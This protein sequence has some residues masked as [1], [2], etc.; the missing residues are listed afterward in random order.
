MIAAADRTSASA[1]ATRAASVTPVSLPPR[2]LTLLAAVF[3][4]LLGLSYHVKGHYLLVYGEH[5]SDAIDLRQKWT[6]QQY[7]L[8]RQNPFDVWIRYGPLT[9]TR[10]EPFHHPTRND[11]IDPRLGLRDPAHPPFGFVSALPFFWPD[12]PAVRLW[13]SAL[14]LVATLVILAYAFHIG[15]RYGPEVGFLFAAAVLAIGGAATTLEVGQ[16]GLV[17]MAFLAGAAWAGER[18]TTGRQILMGLLIGIA[19][20]KITITVPF[21]AALMVGA[22]AV[23]R[24][25]IAFATMIVYCL[26]G[27][28]IAWVVVSTNPLEMLIQ[29]KAMG[30]YLAEGGTLGIAHGLASLGFSP[31]AINL[32]SMTVVMIPALAI[33]W[34]LRARPL[35][36]LFA[37]AAVAGR[38]WTY[39]RSYDDVM[40]I[41][42][43]LAALRILFEL[44]WK[45]LPAL[46]V[47]ALVIVS[48]CAP[49]RV[50][51]IPAFQLAQI[52]IWVIGA[53]WLL[54][55]APRLLP[56]GE[57]SARRA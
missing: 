15:S 32:I 25:W 10:T 54:I 1:S 49:G 21:V 29:L 53:A 19:L 39:H 20:V 27:S 45:N 41:F 38:L 37:I 26:I 33:M 8:Q 44:G 16:Y 46:G 28:L 7:F 57:V 2:W 13:W 51:G 35:L 22:V 31:D 3:L 12:W 11:T 36:E 4:L 40:L 5:R 42:L 43:I 52:F 18:E 56:A 50:L 23:H 55:A 47:A 30:A 9:K 24:R 14:N 6:E 34:M 48:V 17:V